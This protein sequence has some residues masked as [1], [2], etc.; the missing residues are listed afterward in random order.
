MKQKPAYLLVDTS[1]LPDIFEKVV[2]A[3]RLLKNGSCK[4]ASE[5]AQA[6][7]ISRSAFYKYKDCVFPIEEMG[8]DR[9]ITL[10][11]ELDDM[12]GVLSQVL[13]VLASAHTNVLTINQNIPVN[14]SAN[15]TISFRTEG[16]SKSLDALL[17]KLSMTD[18]VK[19]VKIIAGE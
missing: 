15:I 13:K 6:L 14:N 12:P 10:F 9:I 2:E 4:T 1:V 18:G 7:K 5:A 3:K 16:M 8:S 11:F 19:K 17:K